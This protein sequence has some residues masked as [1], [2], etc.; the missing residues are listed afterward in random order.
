MPP[1]PPDAPLLP[2]YQARHAGRG[3]R[4]SPIFEIGWIG[5]RSSGST[6]IVVCGAHSL[7]LLELKMI[8]TDRRAP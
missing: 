1:M 7:A 4:I 2:R 5:W 3:W 8:D 6:A